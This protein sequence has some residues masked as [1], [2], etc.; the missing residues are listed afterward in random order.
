MG[1]I[2][3]AWKIH[4]ERKRDSPPDLFEFA[5]CVWEASNKAVQKEYSV[6]QIIDVAQR[7][8]FMFHSQLTAFD[9]VIA[10]GPLPKDCGIVEDILARHP[11]LRDDFFSTFTPAMMKNW[12]LGKFSVDSVSRCTLL[13]TRTH[14]VAHEHPVVHGGDRNTPATLIASA[15]KMKGVQLAELGGALGLGK[16]SASKVEEK[17]AAV[18]AHIASLDN[19]QT[20]IGVDAALTPRAPIEAANKELFN[21]HRG[22][23]QKLALRNDWAPVTPT[24]LVLRESVLGAFFA[25]FTATSRPIEEGKVRVICD[26]ACSVGDPIAGVPFRIV[27]LRGKAQASLPADLFR[28]VVVELLALSTPDGLIVQSVLNAACLLPE[29]KD[30][31]LT[32]EGSQALGKKGGKVDHKD[33]R[34]GKYC[35]H[36]VT[37]INR[38]HLATLHGSTEDQCEWTKPRKKKIDGGAEPL[39]EVF[40]GHVPKSGMVVRHAF[41]P[42]DIA[43]KRVLVFGIR[44]DSIYNEA[45]TAFRNAKL[46]CI[47]EQSPNLAGRGLALDII[48]EVPEE[49]MVV[50]PSHTQSAL[51]FTTK[52]VLQP[53]L[54]ALP[55]VEVESAAS[56][57]PASRGPM[58][59]TRVAAKE[60][61]CSHSCVCPLKGDCPG[62]SFV[63]LP[64]VEDPRRSKWLL[65][66]EIDD[67][68]WTDARVSLYHWPENHVRRETGKSKLKDHASLPRKKAKPHDTDELEQSVVDAQA[69]QEKCVCSQSEDVCGYAAVQRDDH[70]FTIRKGD[71]RMQAWLPILRPRSTQPERRELLDQPFLIIAAH[72]FND[73]DIRCNQRGHRSLGQGALPRFA[74]R[75]DS[76]PSRAGPPTEAELEARRRLS[77]TGLRHNME[78]RS[79]VRKLIEERE[80]ARESEELG[81]QEEDHGAQRRRLFM[82]ELQR[83]DS[84]C[85]KFTGEP[86]FQVLELLFSYLNARG[87]LDNLI[88]WRSKATKEGGPVRGGGVRALTTFESFVLTLCILHDGGSTASYMMH[89]GVGDVLVHRTYITVLKALDVIFRE[90]Q[91]W[92]SLEQAR[93]MTPTE[94]RIALDL[95]PST[96]L[97]LGDAT[98]RAVQ[99]PSNSTLHCLLY[100]D[101]KQRTTIKY[102]AVAAGNGYICE[103]SRG[104][105]GC[106]SDNALHEREDVGIRIAGDKSTPTL[107]VYDKGLTNHLVIEKHGTALLTPRVKDTGQFNFEQDAELT[108]NVAKVRSPIEKLFRYCRTYKAFDEETFLCSLDIADLEA[109]VVRGLVNMWPRMDDHNL[110][111]DAEK[112]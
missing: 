89:F 72:H 25:Q 7:C 85:R 56:T 80:E 27:L 63:R 88:W 92:P 95:K 19:T 36:I 48:T 82:D 6:A 110:T 14:S 44:G 41:E 103:M 112:R 16:L 35:I 59:R 5:K 20:S 79:I 65:A 84:M 15:E 38:A 26:M 101:Y 17:R 99:N 18:K 49:P 45:Y 94:A 2:L 64:P 31:P 83:N 111:A 42:V 4:S 109:R 53:K 87:L 30:C 11:D 33:C 81:L 96:A 29:G 10:R 68:Q 107:Y 67:K 69:L 93:R 23:R 54:A 52:P 74:P 39:V 37:I 51:M 24:N 32:E 78:A 70:K 47:A 62:K 61:R 106:T 98:E 97:F 58:T 34:G 28:D 104:Y 73:E 9:G 40:F 12:Q 21:E 108:K 3:A 77:D 71:S 50:R 8:A 102:N 76:T 86:S 60:S 13:P 91:P 66:L 100:S 90:H 46:K 22:W 43:D 75:A 105:P 57:T 55:P 1:T